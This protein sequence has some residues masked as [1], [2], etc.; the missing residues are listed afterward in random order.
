MIPVLIGVYLSQDAMTCLG[1][2]FLAHSSFDRMFGYGLKYADSF[3]HTHLGYIG[4]DAGR[5]DESA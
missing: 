5:R 4:K 3:T 1:L 2:V